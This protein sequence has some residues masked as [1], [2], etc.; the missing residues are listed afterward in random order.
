M[1]KILKK[2]EAEKLT[3]VIDTI[4]EF[5]TPIH[6][7][8][9]SLNYAKRAGVYD[10]KYLDLY[11]ELAVTHLEK[12]AGEITEA[13]AQVKTVKALS[14]HRTQL[15]KAFVANAE[16]MLEALKEAN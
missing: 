11:F 12:M 10:E 3:A 9:Q 8:T 15:R 13:I 6:G 4:N 14:A 5:T 16:K 1:A 7:L 2:A